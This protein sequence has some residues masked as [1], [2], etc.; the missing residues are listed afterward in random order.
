MF[1]C[2]CLFIA[3]LFLLAALLAIILGITLTRTT[4][5]TTTTTTEICTPF[6]KMPLV[7]QGT[8]LN[9]SNVNTRISNDDSRSVCVT[10]RATS[11]NLDDIIFDI[12]SRSATPTGGCNAHFALAVS[13]ND[14]VTVYGM[15][16]AYDNGNICFGKNVL[17]DGQFH[18]VCATYDTTTAK[19]CLYLDLY[20]PQ[21]LIRSNVPYNTSLGDVRIGWWP[22]LNRP[23][24]SSGGGL[25]KWLYMFDKAVNQTC[26]SYHYHNYFISNG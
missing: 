2:C 4:T 19:L 24:D 11:V 3:T 18:Q 16:G 21:C 7:D 10:F 8:Y 20:S 5:K 25:I 9:Y 6:W 23:F 1:Q 15:C 22:D 13:N 12:G 26:I 17:H 14:C